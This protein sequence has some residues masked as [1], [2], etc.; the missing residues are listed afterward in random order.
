MNLLNNK[1]RDKIED[2]LENKELNNTGIDNVNTMNIK[3]KNEKFVKNNEKNV[4]KSRVDHEVNV[5]DKDKD[6]V[7]VE[8]DSKAKNI[9]ENEFKD[10]NSVSLNKK[11]IFI[12]NKFKEISKNI[13]ILHH[14]LANKNVKKKLKSEFSSS[15][16]H[17]N[18]ESKSDILIVKNYRG[19][20]KVN[21]TQT[22]TDFEID[23]ISS[24]KIKGMN[25]L[26]KENL[27]LIN[28][29]KDDVKITKQSGL[30]LIVKNYDNNVNNISKNGK[31]ND[32]NDRITINPNKINN[33]KLNNPNISL[34]REN[35]S[36]LPTITYNFDYENE[37]NFK[38]I[39]NNFSCDYNSNHN[40]IN[41]YNDKDK[42]NL[43]NKEI[44]NIKNNDKNKNKYKFNLKTKYLFEELSKLFEK[45]KIAISY[46]AFKKIKNYNYMVN[47]KNSTIQL[48]TFNTNSTTIE[49]VKQTFN[50]L[51][52][53]NSKFYKDELFIKQSS[54]KEKLEE[55][56]KKIRKDLSI[57]VKLT[58]EAFKT[59]NKEL[60]ENKENQEIVFSSKN[61]F[62]ENFSKFK[63]AEY[64]K[65]MLLKVPKI[66][67]KEKNI[68]NLTSIES[69][70]SEKVPI[71]SFDF[72]KIPNFKC[73]FYCCNYFPQTNRK[74]L[75]LSKTKRYI[76]FS[77]LIKAKDKLLSSS[78]V[79]DIKLMEDIFSIKESII[80]EL[81]E[82]E[83]LKMSLK[84]QIDSTK[85]L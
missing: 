9:F 81:K 48:K 46:L 75:L 40:L 56:Y 58:N 52:F 64:K 70:K 50:N 69:I 37:Y 84:L 63:N 8:D 72:I 43:K 57:K 4:N 68:N 32:I 5:K 10:L 3:I 28:N 83:N 42:N 49:K 6:K 7:E 27:M 16:H 21:S 73:E 47:D 1:Y 85:K 74:I 76:C 66:T 80:E 41:N 20:H 67:M 13:K 53:S 71:K 12:N 14:N 23:K 61:T 33:N 38:K 78:N 17:Y 22:Y 29:N 26:K 36:H 62:N 44:H 60:R 30:N 39:L 34:N 65:M 24:M 2:I 19:K 54:E 79:N 51:N 55:K 59:E 77:C 25:K 15:L 35:V 18:K 31:S 45:S 11:D 82:N